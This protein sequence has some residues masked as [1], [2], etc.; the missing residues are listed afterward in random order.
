MESGG[1]RG[2]GSHLS[3]IY[4]VPT[5]SDVTI[6]LDNDLEDGGGTTTFYGHRVVLAKMC[7]YFR[8]M[9]GSFENANQ[10]IRL[11]NFRISAF[12]QCMHFAYFGWT[13][14][15]E[16]MS[17]EQCNQFY[18][19]TE[20]L[21]IDVGD[22]FNKW[23]CNKIITWEKDIWTLLTMGVNY[24][25]KELSEKCISHFSDIANEFLRFESFE[26]L[27]LIAVQMVVACKAMNCTR[28]ELLRTVRHWIVV[29]GEMIDA[30]EKKELLLKVSQRKIICYKGKKLFLYGKTSPKHRTIK[31]NTNAEVPT[32]PEW[33]LTTVKPY[34]FTSQMKFQKCLLID[35]IIFFLQ[36]NRTF[37]LEY[38]YSQSE[39]DLKFE[40]KGRSKNGVK[41]LCKR[42]IHII[43]D[44][45]RSN[46]RLVRLFFPAVKCCALNEI[47][48]A[49]SWKAAGVQPNIYKF[50]IFKN[51]LTM[52]QSSFV[53]H[54]YYQEVKPKNST[55][56]NCPLSWDSDSD[57]SCSSSYRCTGSE[58]DDDDSAKWF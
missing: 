8:K 11:Q 39:I 16:H 1:D 37:G 49:F 14:K 35:G 53:S 56:G 10:V 18:A 13:Y 51:D 41:T 22:H 29:N 4:N 28:A 5:F 20:L 9:L 38:M 21:M 43:S 19:M 12:E 47:T 40:I 33:L 27:P 3:R 48:F 44:F 31:R 7:E 30:K 52:G 50:G 54:I 15:L 55:C 17:L 23:I 34:A 25:L 58:S 42:N 26:K 6:I 2:F 24:G 36:S 46:L 32:P 45:T 57:N